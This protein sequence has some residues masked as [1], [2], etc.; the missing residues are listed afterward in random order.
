[1]A[2][3]LLVL[4]CLCD[5][6][7]QVHMADTVLVVTYYWPWVS[8]YSFIMEFGNG[9]EPS[10]RKVKWDVSGSSWLGIPWPV[11]TTPYYVPDFEEFGVNSY[12]YV[13]INWKLPKPPSKIHIKITI[14]YGR[15]TYYDEQLHECYELTANRT[16]RCNR[17][18]SGRYMCT[19]D[20]DCLSFQ[21][22][23]WRFIVDNKCV[24]QDLKW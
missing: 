20:E 11:F 18:E 24:L 10:P 22:C 2:A 17:V 7:A 6:Y 9:T 13:F 5:L 3:W 21:R 15:K 12:D 4:L 16:Q 1:M 19:K 23:E 8:Q 14:N